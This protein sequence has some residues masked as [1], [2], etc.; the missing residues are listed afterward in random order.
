MTI[1]QLTLVAVSVAGLFVWIGTILSRR[2][3][4]PLLLPALL[5][6]GLSLAAFV[7]DWLIASAYFRP[8]TDQVIPRWAEELG[9]GI[10]V[11]AASSTLAFLYFCCATC[12]VSLWSLFHRAANSTT[13]NQAMERTTDR[14]APHI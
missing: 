13:P 6:L 1:N 11:L 4:R 7:T 12:V 9:I 14:S 10:A 2:F 8:H 3:R 5:F